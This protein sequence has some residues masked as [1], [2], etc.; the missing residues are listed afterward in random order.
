M[1][2]KDLFYNQNKYKIINSSSLDNLTDT[3]ESPEYIEEFSSEKD[4]FVPRLDF[5]IPSNFAHYGSAEL[6][7]EKSFERIYQQYPYDGSER[8]KLKYLN[9]S[10]YLDRWIFEN[11]YPR[12]NGHIR[13]G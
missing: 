5:S 12:T 9:S 2:I 11:A 6:Y 4:K 3:L 1:S 10:S 7:Y 13:I 8:E